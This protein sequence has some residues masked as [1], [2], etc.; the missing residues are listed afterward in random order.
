MI[1]D[2]IRGFIA[3]Q[4]ERNAHLRLLGASEAAHRGDEVLDGLDHVLKTSPKR[5]FSVE[6]AAKMTGMH[7]KSIYRKANRGEIGSQTRKHGTITLSEAD[8]AR[9]APKARRTQQDAVAD[10]L[11]DAVLAGL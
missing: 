10:H 9:L 4:R 1:Q 3:D 2:L 5:T 7:P 6:E 11:A 8:V